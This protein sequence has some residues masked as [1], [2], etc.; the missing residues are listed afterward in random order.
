MARNPYSKL[1][2]YKHWADYGLYSVVTAT[3]DRLPPQ[4]G[5]IL[6]RVLDHMHVVDQ[7][8]RRH[9]Q[10]RPHG[11][12]APRSDTV[13]ALASLA[14]GAGEIDDWYVS[15][16]ESLPARD[17]DEPVDFRFTNGNRPG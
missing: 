9:L 2:G 4:D 16:V 8:F 17:F 3:F 13:P 7:I 11:F 14:A 1:V 10:G 15:Y 5:A 6:L 12:H